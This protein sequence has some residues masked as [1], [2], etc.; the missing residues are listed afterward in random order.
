MTTLITLLAD[1]LA[2]HDENDKGAVTVTDETRYFV[3]FTDDG[4]RMFTLVADDMPMTTADVLSQYPRAVEV[5][6]EEQALLMNG[7]RRH[8]STGVMLPP[9]DDRDAADLR[10]RRLDEVERRE[11]IA[12]N[13]TADQVLE[14]IETDVPIPAALKA[15]RQ[16]IR[17]HAGDLRRQ[18]ANA[19]TLADLDAVDVLFT[20][21][22]L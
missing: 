4:H 21:T 8:P 12:L 16:S 5:T 9:E 22:G 19:E 7:Y 17:D 6:A 14:C 18:L 1:I 3:M 13:I 11:S 2:V 15:E 10:R 20:V